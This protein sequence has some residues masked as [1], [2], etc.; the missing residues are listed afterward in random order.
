M[1]EVGVSLG[2]PLMLAS[3]LNSLNYPTFVCAML[4]TGAV[5]VTIKGV[6]SEAD[7]VAGIDLELTFAEIDSKCRHC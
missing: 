3:L 1:V 5:F 4:M 2:M 6:P 7:I